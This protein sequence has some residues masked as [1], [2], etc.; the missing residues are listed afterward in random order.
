MSDLI[1]QS[2][3]LISESLPPQNFPDPAAQAF[4][5]TLT[6]EQSKLFDEYFLEESAREDAWCLSLFRR[7][8]K[9]GLYIPGS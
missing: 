4:I 1:D 8:V 7:T 3:Y 2:Y 9:L 6:P 5:A